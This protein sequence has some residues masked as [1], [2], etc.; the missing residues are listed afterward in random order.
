MSALTLTKSKSCGQLRH[1]SSCLMMRGKQLRCNMLLF[2]DLRQVILP[3]HLVA[4]CI[5]LHASSTTSHSLPTND[6]IGRSL[7]LSKPLFASH[8]LTSLVASGLCVSEAGKTR[9]RVKQS[10]QC[11]KIRHMEPLPFPSVSREHVIG[12]LSSI[13]LLDIDPPAFIDRHCG[14]YQ[15]LFLPLDMLQF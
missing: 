13:I 9:R 6:G 10:K 12:Y 7:I 3:L 2:I 4:P 14:Q 15:C 5:E 11:Y 1:R 8:K